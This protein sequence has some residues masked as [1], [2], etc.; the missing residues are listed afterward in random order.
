MRNQ[1]VHLKESTYN[2]MIDLHKKYY[3]DSWQYV[4]FDETVWRAIEGAIIQ[5][6]MNKERSE[7]S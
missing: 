1:V 7:V 4:P 3:P 5:R 2:K 6:E